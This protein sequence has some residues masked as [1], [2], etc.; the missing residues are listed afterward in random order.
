MN[1]SAKRRIKQHLG[2]AGGSANAS[3]ILT[4]A[5][6]L[7]VATVTLCILFGMRSNA[8]VSNAAPQALDL[9]LV[10]FA[11]GFDD[12]LGVTNAGSGDDRLFV[13]EQGGVIK[14]VHPD[15]TV[16]PT[17]FLDIS[18]RV[19]SSSNEEG[20]LGLTFHPDYA[21]N[22]YFY[23]NYTHT[24]FNIRRTRISRFSV[25]DDPNVADPDSESI[26]LT[27][28][29]PQANHNAG[30]IHFGPDGYLYVPLGDGGGAGDTGNN[31]QNLSLLLGKIARIDVDSG[32]GS[33]PDCQGGGTGNY[34]IP[35]TNPL[36]DGAGG[37]CDEIWA[38]GL[39]NPWRSSFD[40]LTGDLYIGD[41]GQNDW[42]EINYQPVNA[43]GGENYGW[44]CYEGD[45]AFNTDGC[46]PMINYT[47]PIFEY[48][49]T[50]NG[51]TV[52]G[53]YVY[54]GS[55]YPAMYGHY[56]LA[57]YCSG[58]FWDLAPDGGGWQ[59]TK[60]TNLS[61]FGYVAFGEDASGELY[62]VNISSNTLYRLQENTLFDH[63]LFLPLIIKAG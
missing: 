26:L 27:V 10:A 47:F 21:S 5:L 50:D 45:H 9:A 36:V 1:C 6:S 32:S 4:T 8:A 16:L 15:G 14:I 17:P 19:D 60:H 37:T 28:R 44:R 18:G 52:I 41:V 11:T 12:P 48:N 56:L 2:N 46:G 63:P 57:D 24:S 53:G 20:L 3:P 34:T 40:R 49:Q 55:Q 31:A 25:S 35:P 54:R 7:I 59:A 43:G 39:R 33:A 22:G 62:V 29:Q 30:D 42:E 51:C 23:L 61:G 13:V 38:I 58:N